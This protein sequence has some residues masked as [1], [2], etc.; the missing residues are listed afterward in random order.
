MAISESHSTLKVEILCDGVPLQ[1]HVNDDEEDSRTTVTRYIEAESG[2]NF[3]IHITLTRPFPTHMVIYHIYLDGK[4]RS[5]RFP[6]D[7]G[8][9]HQVEDHI[10][11]VRY[12]VDRRWFERKF[13]FSELDVGQCYHPLWYRTHRAHDSQ[14]IQVA[15][16]LVH[17]SWGL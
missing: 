13:C 10:S 5:G 6:K 11:G 7:F 16:L 12:P 2:K 14:M 1:E 8:Y 9:N 15:S 3:E 17:S 4:W